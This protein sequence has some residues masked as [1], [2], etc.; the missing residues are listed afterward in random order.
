VR[1]LISGWFAG[2]TVGSGAYTDQILATL[3]SVAASG[4]RFDLLPRRAG[5]RLPAALEKLAFE[6]VAFPRA[7][8]GFDLAHVPYWA[9]PLC[10]L[11]PT[12]VTVHDLI[13]L[14][15]EPYRA[16]RSVRLYTALVARATERAA[17]VLADSEHTAADIRRHLD[18]DPAR[19]HVVSLGVEPRFRPGTEASEVRQRYRLPERF[20][21]YLGGFDVRK[22]VAVLAA[23]WRD[24]FADT[25][26][27]L[28]L[29]GRLPGPGDR[30][31]PDPRE[32]A[33]R[34]GLPEGAVAFIG[35]VAEEDKP[36]LYG[37]ASVFA[38]P[39]R[40][41][42]FGLPPLEAM[43]CGTPVVCSDATSLPEIVGDAAL[44]VDPDDV[45][46]WAERLRAVAG[47][48]SL[49][50]RLSSAGPERAAAFTWERTATATLAVYRA[51][52]AA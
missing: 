43:A 26:L 34:A 47:D 14:V 49:A 6:Q 42:G 51:V 39:S 28:V 50:A 12:V 15:L 25:G 38:F 44:L 4:D 23:A 36:A 9:P 20:G 24:V 32:L 29:A 45:G 40:F 11:V 10:P 31:H 13:P 19:V 33:G 48:V 5:G 35:H 52:A 17:A 46:G 27:P 1:V 3:P 18:I 7:S 8:R 22:N 30:L 21:L 2:R 16:R 41:E 37:A